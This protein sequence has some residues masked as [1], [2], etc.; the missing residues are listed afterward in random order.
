M[1]IR[2]KEAVDITRGV[3]DA[4]EG[5]FEDAKQAFEEARNLD[6]TSFAL[7]ACLE[8]LE[9]VLAGRLGIEAAVHF[10][11]AIGY[12][13]DGML[14]EAKR[15]LDRAIE[16]EPE[17]AL[18]WYA[19]GVEWWFM[20]ESGRAIEDYSRAI[21]ADP[22]MA[23]AYYAR[24]I[25]WSSW[26]RDDDRALQDYTKA[27]ELDPGNAQVY[28]GRGHIHFAF[29]DWDR[30]IADF[31]KAIEIKPDYA[32]AYVNRGVVYLARLGNKTL[33]CADLKKASDLGEPGPHLGALMNGDCE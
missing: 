13:D 17:F 32:E 20:E 31:S 27:I 22:E 14:E 10:F 2:E 11:R 19:R 24:A 3:E 1:A 8:A 29:G 26:M 7:R 4:V 21:D 30:A 28:Y 23:E 5:R 15:D 6:P 12:E 25:V 18:A 9:A 33:G 16:L